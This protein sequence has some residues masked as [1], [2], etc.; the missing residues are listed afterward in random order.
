[1][2]ESFNTVQVTH[3]TEH[4]GLFPVN[5]EGGESVFVRSRACLF[6]VCTCLVDYLSR[7]LYT[8]CFTAHSPVDLCV[9]LPIVCCESRT[10]CCIH[11][12]ISLVFP[13][14]FCI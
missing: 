11:S 7:H 14:F 10:V 4:G 6:F 12:V 5:Q 3:E 2:S 8:S 9:G 1:M 13:P